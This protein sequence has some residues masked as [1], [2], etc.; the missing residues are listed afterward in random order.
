M[1]TLAF[2]CAFAPLVALAC[3][4]SVGEGA[5][6]SPDAA[7]T[8]VADAGAADAAPDPACDR[9]A[10][11]IREGLEAAR[12]KQKL[13][14]AVVGVETPRCGVRVFHADSPTSKDVVTDDSLWRVGSV[15]K[16]YVSAAVLS[17]VAE[18]KLG[19]DDPLARFVP[20]YPNAA[21]ITVRSLLNHTSGTYNYT[22]SPE[23]SAALG[24]APE[25][26]Y[27]GEELLAF[28]TA[29]PPAFE[30]GKSWGYSNTNYV[31]LGLVIEKVTGAKVGAVVRERAIAKAGLA[32]TFFD[33]EEPL[34]GEMTPGYFGRRVVTNELDPSVAWAAGAMVASPRDLLAW[35]HA[36]YG[37]DRVLAPASKAELFTWV[38]EPGYGLGVRQLPESSTAGHGKGVGHGG[39]I[40]GFQTYAFWFEDA[41]TGVVAIAADTAGDAD[42][43]GKMALRSLER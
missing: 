14:H 38:P 40:F 28:A 1:R 4:A 32:H 15:T 6:P 17:L 12:A 11:T 9:E 3:S 41:K 20:T 43:I 25:K 27:S 16:T 23:F 8:P 19:L 10:A 22:N 31:L 2:F 5:A 21:T 13:V 33:G 24:A 30:P 36:L 37:S 7:P 39:S 29:H 18:G 26:K 42:A 34:G 35:L